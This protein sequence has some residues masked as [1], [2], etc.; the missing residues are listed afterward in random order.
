MNSVRKDKISSEH[1]P[2]IRKYLKL[3][4][5][6][7]LPVLYLTFSLL[8]LLFLFLFPAKIEITYT[9]STIYQFNG[10]E[11]GSAKAVVTSPAGHPLASPEVIA[12]TNGSKAVLTSDYKWLHTSLSLSC[13]QEESLH[14]TFG[15][16]IQA[17]TPL[18]HDDLT[19]TCAYADGTKIPVTDFTLPDGVKAGD[20]KTIQTAYGS[21]QLETNPWTSVDINYY[22]FDYAGRTADPERLTGQVTFLDGTIK[23]IPA[24]DLELLNKRPLTV[25][26]TSLMVKTPYG[27]FEIPVNVYPDTDPV[28]KTWSRQFTDA[29]ENGQIT[30][31]LISSTLCIL[32]QKTAGAALYHIYSENFQLQMDL[33]EQNT[34]LSDDTGSHKIHLAVPFADSRNGI[35]IKYG[36]VSDASVPIPQ[37]YTDSGHEQGASGTEFAI[38]IDSFCFT[39]ASGTT[40]YDLIA[41]GVIRTLRCGNAIDLKEKKKDH[42]AGRTGTILAAGS[43]QDFFIVSVTDKTTDLS[44][45]LPADE[46]TC[47]HWLTGKRTDL[48]MDGSL[49][50]GEKDVKSSSYLVFTS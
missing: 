43:D 49:L 33:S 46:I 50:T 45:L 29:Y 20:P 24:S 42:T 10:I 30:P 38:T 16:D 22:G 23:E 28:E 35:L 8:L 40:A 39:P 2:A 3:S 32:E 21:V 5:E 12:D 41:N 31:L 27:P 9:G 34:G 7:W 4:G 37:S 26:D 13:V 25:Q 14:C 11:K 44:T 18:T 15:Q 6:Q 19:I 47:A 1:R 36:K 17:G 48:Y